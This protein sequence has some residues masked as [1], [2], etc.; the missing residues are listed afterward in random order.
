MTAAVS[1]GIRSAG[2]DWALRRDFARLLVVAV[3]LPALILCALLAWSQAQ[4]QRNNAAVQLQSMGEAAAGDFDEFLR[5][6]GAATA[7]L[8][9]QRSDARGLVDRAGWESDLRR[10]RAHYPA[11]AHMR[12]LDARGRAIASDPDNVATDE[13]GPCFLEPQRTGH[14]VVTD[15]AGAIDG[16]PLACVGAPL[17]V[18]GRFA[19]VVAGSL[20]LDEYAGTRV[21]WLRSHGFEAVLVDRGG[22]VAYASEQLPVA[23]GAAL[24]SIA[25]GDALAAL[26]VDGRSG[27]HRIDGVLRDGADAYAVAVPLQVGWRLLVLLPKRTLDAQLWRSIGTM[28][29]LLVAV[30]AGVLGIAWWQMRRLTASIGK[31]LVQMQRFALEHTSAPIAPDSMP[32]ELA[33]L[34]DAM[35]QLNVRLAD[36]WGT[37]HRS[38]QEQQRLRASLE[39]VVDARER[40]I[41][42]RTQELRNAV[43]ELDRLSR[44]DALTGCLNYRGFREVAGQ[45]WR[46]A[47]TEGKMLSALALDIDYFKSY[48]DRYGHPRGDNALKRF[49]GAVRSALYHREDVVVRPGGEEFIVFLPDTTL[50]QALRVGERICASVLHADIAHAGSPFGMLTVSIGVATN[51]PDDGD[52]PEVMLARADAALYRAKNAGRNRVSL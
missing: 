3:V 18:D 35:N 19:G 37:T 4:T 13:Q 50:E 47:R 29:G 40:E 20:R 2:S 9:A 17:R 14:P 44:T 46:D 7:V 48:N 42:Q 26:P 34:A 32:Q 23:G 8:A 28:I 22:R 24:A 10:V 12:A 45:L 33:P 21:D 6:H 52:D 49:A 39:Q 5:V 51:L 43:S 27:M 38:L 41:A 16:A 1:L 25:G 15:L 30:A 36:A 11:F 31:L